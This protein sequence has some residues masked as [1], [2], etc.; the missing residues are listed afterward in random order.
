MSLKV[1]HLHLLTGCFYH[2]SRWLCICLVLWTKV[3]V[4]TTTLRHALSASSVSAFHLTEHPRAP[5]Q[6]QQESQVSVGEQQCNAFT[7]AFSGFL[8]L[9]PCFHL[10]FGGGAPFSFS[11]VF[12]FFLS[13][14]LPKFI[15]TVR[16]FPLYGMYCI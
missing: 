16:F 15:E 6:I 8:T 10:R 3:M 12:S 13:S 2:F 4:A 5:Q 7:L 11:A 9:S 1:L 14:E